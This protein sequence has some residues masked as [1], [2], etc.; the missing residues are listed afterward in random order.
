MDDDHISR[1]TLLKGLLSLENAVYINPLVAA[2]KD[3][4]L[5]WFVDSGSNMKPQMDSPVNLW[6]SACF[7]TQK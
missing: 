3:Y 6:K 2:F 4:W 7:K 1:L 5:K